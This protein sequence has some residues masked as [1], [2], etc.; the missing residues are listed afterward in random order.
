MRC[1]GVGW[2]WDP[3][4]TGITYLHAALP[5]HLHRISRA[6]DL[7]PALA[8]EQILERVVVYLHRGYMYL[9]DWSGP[10]LLEK[11]V[12]CARAYA[13]LLLCAFWVGV[14]FGIELGIELGLS[15]GKDFTVHREGFA[16]ARAPIGDEHQ[17]VPVDDRAQQRLDVAENVPLG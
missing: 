12:K 7:Q 15:H 3:S 1:G 2:G 4:Q 13:R 11:V 10:E 5:H 6:T 9:D 17:I 16:R 14:E 8:S